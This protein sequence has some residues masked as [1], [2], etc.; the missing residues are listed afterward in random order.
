MNRIS[1]RT[2]VAA[3]GAPLVI[4]ALA[5]AWIGW[6]PTAVST[7]TQLTRA[8]RARLGNLALPFIANR[9]QFAHP[10]AFYAPTFSGAAFV[11]RGGTLVMSLPPRPG[12]A[13]AT[14]WTLV[15][16]PVTDRRPRARGVQPAT[17]HVNVFQ[18]RNA[19][20]WQQGLPTYGQVSLGEVWPGIDYDVRAHGAN[21]E[22]LFTVQ[23]GASAD[24]IRMRVRGA[25]S[26]HVEHDRLVAE[27]GNGPVTLSRPRAWQ[28]IDGK[29]HAVPV[30]FTVSADEYGF[31][32]GAH[33]RKAPV[34]IDPYV[35]TTYLGGANGSSGANALQMLTANGNVYLAGSTT[36]AAFPG[37]AGGAQSALAGASDAFVAE[38][39]PDLSQ[40]VQATYLGGSGDDSASALAIAPA[41]TAMAGDL[42]LAGTT[43]SPDFPGTTG[44]A[45]AQCGGGATACQND[46]DAFVAVLAPDLKTLIQASY[47]GGSNID[48]GNA[49]AIAP[50]AA[51]SVGAV[52]VAGRTLSQDFPGVSGGAQPQ[53]ASGSY[54]G[55]VA[56]FNPNLTTLAQAS[57][58]GGSAV[59]EAYAVGVSTSGSVYLAGDTSSSDFPC[60][61]AGGPPPAGGA[62]ASGAGSGAQPQFAGGFDAFVARMNSSL[63]SLLQASYLGGTDIDSADVLAVAPASTTQAGQVY[64]GGETYSN[65][66]PGM[67]N[68]AQSQLAGDAD[69]FVARFSANL[70]TL[71]ADSYLGGSGSDNVQAMAFSGD[72]LYVAGSTG[73]GDFPCTDSSGPTPPGGGT[74]TQQHAGAQFLYGGGSSDGFVALFNST[75]FS[76]AQASYVGGL[77]PDGVAGVGLAPAASTFAGDVFVGG[78]TNSSNLQATSGAAQSALTGSGDAFAAAISPD[79]EG[80][81]VKLDLTVSGPATI[82]KLAKTTMTITATNASTNGNDATN[83]IVDDVINTST[84]I[85]GFGYD[86][87]TTSQGKCNYTGGVLVCT[88]GILPA[89]GGTATITVNLKAGNLTGDTTSEVTIHADQALDTSSNNDV[90]HV[91]TIKAKPVT[92]G[93]G[94]FG[95]L[96]LV[97]LAMFALGVTYAK[98][99]RRQTSRD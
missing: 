69:G 29:R 32:L 60:A 13:S 43:R 50:S 21:I 23:P 36:S 94:A 57:Y 77:S 72:N 9:G 15:E 62:C 3:F 1:A 76:L 25:R 33:D 79:L 87:S 35:R 12:Q 89:N 58:L 17:T 8:E 16:S 18:G 92:N 6:N 61:N 49:L 51:T 45:Q 88:L 27:T 47:L 67:S 74:C 85:S 73:S 97:L 68:G 7:A 54:E 59:D 80:P 63:T 14:G 19:A 37:T 46:G 26:L 11:T 71:N 70:Q 91:T 39:S 75:L 66:M 52:Y 53:I 78:T 31:R 96:L 2:A 83:V 93:S 44:G 55:Y 84:S 48:E 38:L 34:V 5:A 4:A 56:R 86:S 99:Q 22:R 28:R 81:Q 41:G 65:D 40:L 64:I 82:Y 98:R 30:D 42:Y 95:W 10:V 24:A 20:R 90:Q